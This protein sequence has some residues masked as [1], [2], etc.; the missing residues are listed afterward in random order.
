MKIPKLIHQIWSGLDEPLPLNFETFGNTWKRDYPDWQYEFWD[1][2]R[3]ENFI[4]QYYPQY[5]DLYHK[6]HYNVQRWDIIR[7]L[8]LDKMGGMYVDFDYESLLPLTD[9]ITD[10]TCCFAVEAEYQDAKTGNLI[11]VC[12][13]AL[14][15]ST[16]GHPYMRKI[17]DR[18]FS[19]R[20]MFYNPYPK[21]RCVLYT[22]GPM[23]LN[24]LYK[25]LT[26]E[27]KNDIY[28]IPS[29]YVTPWSVG[30]AISYRKGH[31]GPDFD[32]PLEGAYAI[33]YFYG[34]WLNTNH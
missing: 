2:D 17:I 16:P 13:N 34:T 29:R 32:D 21:S 24:E 23:L 28:L 3:I 4:L 1:N 27:E 5:Y 18:V 33:H 30:Q 31:R 19:K 20:N 11:S 12:N 14:M 7:Y 25:T 6:F 26:D 8:I 15:L 9:L 22:T 10:K